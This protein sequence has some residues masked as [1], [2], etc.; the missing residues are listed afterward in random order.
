MV[1]GSN[2]IPVAGE[3]AVGYVNPLLHKNGTVARTMAWNG[4]ELLIRNG[5]RM[6]EQWVEQRLS[7]AVQRY[8][9]E[10]SNGQAGAN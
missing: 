1:T 3:K 2:G 7:P 9:L 6:G 5:C 8:P 10:M 4:C